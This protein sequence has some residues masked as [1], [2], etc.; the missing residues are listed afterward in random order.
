[1]PRLLYLD[2]LRAVCML[3][4]VVLHAYYL[5]DYQPAAGFA[6]FVY[7]FCM[8]TFFIISGFVL[9]LRLHEGDAF[10]LKDR[11]FRLAWPLATGLIFINPLTLAVIHGGFSAHWWADL[12][13]RAQSGHLFVHLWFLFCLIGFVLTSPLQLAILKT[14]GLRHALQALIARV[15]DT[16]LP[17]ALTLTI[18]ALQMGLGAAGFTEIAIPFDGFFKY[19]WAFALGLFFYLNPTLWDAAHRPGPLPFVVAALFWLAM[20]DGWAEPG[21]ALYAALHAGRMASSTVAISFGLLWSFRR[22]CNV[23]TRSW[24]VLSE[25]AL[26]TYLLQWLVLHML[27]GPFMALGL[28]GGALFASLIAATVILKMTTH[29]LLVKPVPVLALL[30]NGTPLPRVA[31]RPSAQPSSS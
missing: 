12:V 16:Y 7:N 27:V 2:N 24:R 20:L 23:R 26:T 29:H 19:A 3:F 5:V 9:A 6:V 31:A 10:Q 11:V 8:G 13:A 17:V 25:G 14:V 22:Y 15:P 21:T 1:M 28:S 18:A 30:L 4:V